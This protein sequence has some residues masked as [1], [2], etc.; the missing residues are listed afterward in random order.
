[1]R[2]VSDRWLTT[3]RGSHRPVFQARVVEP[4]PSPGFF[5]PSGTDPAGTD[6]PISGGYVQWDVESDILATCEITIDDPSYYPT[7]AS[8]L[9]A[10][11]GNELFL[12]RGIDY[13]DGSVEWVSLGYYR[14]N[15]VE[16]DDARGGSIRVQGSDR[17]WRL[18]RNPVIRGQFDGSLYTNGTFLAWMVDTAIGAG[19]ITIV[20]DD[21]ALRDAALSRVINVDNDRYAVVDELMQSLGK[22]WYFDY[23][24]YLVVKTAPSATTPV[25]TADAGAGG[26]LTKAGR[27]IS[28]D[29][30]SNSVLVIGDVGDGSASILPIASASDGN[31]ASP[32]WTGSKFGSL[33]TVVQDSLITTSAKA[34]TLAR[35]VLRTSLGFPKS[36]DFSTVPNA[37]L[38]PWD[39]VRLL[40]PGKVDE[41]QV[42]RRLTIPLSTG[43][44]FD[45]ET[46]SYYTGDL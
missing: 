19:A 16:Q 37:A 29:N 4:G 28:D 43:G 3:I 9:L 44:T 7:D 15:S 35:S 23:R 10:P 8:G 41:T 17:M 42:L 2:A 31:I 33:S 14:I 24:G 11:Y 27:S 18:I 34:D 32:T 30:V 26:V 21:T 46:L 45:A 40:L 20:W 36:L 12:R 13:G 38:E 39:P 1:M 6:V 22:I 25:W 5:M